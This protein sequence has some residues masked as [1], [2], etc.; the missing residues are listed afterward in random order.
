MNLRA[1]LPAVAVILLLASAGMI[2]FQPISRATEWQRP[3][4]VRACELKAQSFNK[5]SWKVLSRDVLIPSPTNPFAF[6]L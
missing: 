3:Q 6:A 5:S 1:H 4:S 2:I